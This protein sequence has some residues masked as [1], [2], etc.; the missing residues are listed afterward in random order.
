[1]QINFSLRPFQRNGILDVLTYPQPIDALTEYCPSGYR[2]RGFPAGEWL[3]AETIPVSGIDVKPCRIFY[4][5]GL[6]KE[7]RGLSQ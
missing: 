5:F 1:V 4:L 6:F 3:R 2:R 7:E